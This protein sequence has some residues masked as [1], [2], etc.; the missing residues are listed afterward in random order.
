MFSHVPFLLSVR[1]L[2]GFFLKVS[3]LHSGPLDYPSAE[4]F[5]G[6]F[7]VVLTHLDLSLEAVRLVLFC[8]SVLES[9]DLS[10]GPGWV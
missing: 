9:Q 4:H 8:W 2:K 10:W 5:P 6:P 7:L 3:R 1:F